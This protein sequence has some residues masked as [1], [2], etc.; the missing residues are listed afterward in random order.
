MYGTPRPHPVLLE[1][2]VGDIEK[3]RSVLQ[4]VVFTSYAIPD[5]RLKE[6][7]V[8]TTIMQNDILSLVNDIDD[9]L[10]YIVAQT[11]SQSMTD[12]LE[13]FQAQRFEVSMIQQE[14]RYCCDR[15]MIPNVKQSELV[16]R[17]CARVYKYNELIFEKSSFLSGDKGRSKPN[18]YNPM[19]NFNKWMDKITCKDERVDRAVLDRI[20]AKFEKDHKGF[21]RGK[22]DIS[23]KAIRR[24]LKQLGL[25]KYNTRLAYI[26]QYLTLQQPPQFSETDVRRIA[27]YYSQIIHIYYHISNKYNIPY[28]PH[29]IAKIIENIFPDDADKQRIK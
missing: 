25:S 13:L 27:D 2:L 17:I 28:C 19:R 8:M 7:N 22:L 20:V 29:I 15:K 1:Q 26:R 23:I 16:C 10:T 21:Q 4:L 9:Q 6:Q 24:C 3:F 18:K 11:Q 12:E 14:I 5:R